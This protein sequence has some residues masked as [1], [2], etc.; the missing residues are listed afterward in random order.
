MNT[1]GYPPHPTMKTSVNTRKKHGD[2]DKLLECFNEM[3]KNNIQPDIF[4]YNTL[5]TLYAKKMN[6]SMVEKLV[7]GLAGMLKVVVPKGE[8]GTKEQKDPVDP[9]FRAL[10]IDIVGLCAAKISYIF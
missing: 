5:I 9:L 3:K 2:Y 7:N 8:K 6:F 4:T 1:T 10:C